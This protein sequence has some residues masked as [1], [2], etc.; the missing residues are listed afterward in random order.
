MTED[1]GYI[2]LYRQA[3]EN[4]WLKTHKIWVF[5]SY[6]LL[7]ARYKDGK[8]M[9]QFN[10]VELKPGQFIFGRH[11]AAEDTNLSE[12]SIRTCLNF[13]KDEGTITIE[14]T[15]RFSIITLTNWET[16][17]GP[18]NESNQP[19]NQPLTN[20]QPAANH[21]QEGK[22]V[23]KKTKSPVQNDANFDAFWSYYPKK[24]GK[25]AARKAFDKIAP[26]DDML[27]KIVAAVIVQS[28]CRQWT[29]DGG[30]FIPHA[31]TWLNQERW[32]DEIDVAPMTPRQRE[33]AEMPEG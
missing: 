1:T 4:G 11:R 25:Q 12:Q 16:Y 21:K 13:L 8:T 19:I 14:S 17:Q 28:S 24:V 15:T 23:K 31:S 5:L 7:K 18:E 2:K 29:K 9:E 26:D 6:C 32:G 27:S 3:L 10:H 22:K 20:E 30:E 33:L